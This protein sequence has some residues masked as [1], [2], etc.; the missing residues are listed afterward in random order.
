ML[1]TNLSSGYLPDVLH[2]ETDAV[3]GTMEPDCPRGAS[4][5]VRRCQARIPD[6]ILRELL[7]ITELLY[8]Y[9]RV[10]KGSITQSEAKFKSWD[11]LVL[12]KEISDGSN[13]RS[14]DP[15]HRTNGSR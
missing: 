10:F 6:C 2:V 15:Q 13:Y 14:Y 11:D 7:Q 8:G 3:C 5:I 9:A 4:G 12:V 1:H